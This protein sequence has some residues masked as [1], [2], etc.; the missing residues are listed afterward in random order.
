MRTWVL[1]LFCL[2]VIAAAANADGEGKGGDGGKEGKGVKRN[3]AKKNDKGDKNPGRNGNRL[4]KPTRNGPKGASKPRKADGKPTNKNVAGRPKS[5]KKRPDGPKKPQRP[6]PV[7][8]KTHPRQLVKQK[9]DCPG[10]CVASEACDGR[11]KKGL[12]GDDLVCCLPKANRADKQGTTIKRF[13][14]PLAACSALKGECRKSKTGCNMDEKRFKNKKNKAYCDK[15]SCVCCAKLCQE[16]AKC[17]KLGGSCML[18]KESKKMCMGSFLAGAKY[19]KG[20]KCGCCV[21]GPSTCKQKK[22]CTSE[23]G[24]CVALGSTCAGKILTKNAN[25][26]NYCKGSSCGC[27]LESEYGNRACADRRGFPLS[28]S[29][30]FDDRSLLGKL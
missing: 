19:C 8:E 29:Y 10:E 20:N 25:G 15:K 27:C 11:R 13:C 17:K 30:L 6:K 7:G 9:E 14:K 26:K 4:E 24:T 16:K 2:V 23:K 12:C 5:Q 18:K 28:S 21:T 22:T 3:N 1:V